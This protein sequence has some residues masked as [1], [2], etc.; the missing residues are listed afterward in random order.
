MDSGITYPILTIYVSPGCMFY[1]FKTDCRI[2]N[3]L[4]QKGGTIHFN[5]L[6]SVGSQKSA[7]EASSTDVPRSRCC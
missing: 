1:I 5:E 2:A 3:Q 6:K 7:G 4:S